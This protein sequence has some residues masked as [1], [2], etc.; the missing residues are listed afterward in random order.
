MTLWCI[1]DNTC[2]VGWWACLQEECKTSAIYNL[3]T[4]SVTQIF[5]PCFILTCFVLR[6]VD[7]V[8]FVLLLLISVCDVKVGVWVCLTVVGR[9]EFILAVEDASA[10]A[11]EGGHAEPAESPGQACGFLLM[12]GRAPLIP[13]HPD[14][15]ASTEVQC[16][17]KQPFSLRCWSLGPNNWYSL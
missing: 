16:L 5:L 8:V 9:V 13:S 10:L 17:W 2:R 1:Q 4:E 3:S 12:E 14:L 7:P 11:R 15:V 6:L